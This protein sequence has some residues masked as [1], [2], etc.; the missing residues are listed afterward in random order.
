MTKIHISQ[1]PSTV[2]AFSSVQN[3]LS[4]A[5]VLNFDSTSPNIEAR[6]ALVINATEEINN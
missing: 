6:H 3:A 1:R 4:A 2:Q 5:L